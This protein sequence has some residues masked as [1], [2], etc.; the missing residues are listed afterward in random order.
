MLCAQ[1]IRHLRA[2]KDCTVAFFVCDFR[3]GGLNSCSHIL[4]TIAGH[5][6]K[7]HPTLV[8]FIYGQY[9][10]QGLSPSKANLKRLL[11]DLLSGVACTRLVVD[12][13]DECNDEEQKEIL[14]V[15]LQFVDIKS[16][17]TECKAVAFS[18]DVAVINKS[19]KKVLMISLKDEIAAA[20]NSIK[21][22]VQ[23]ELHQIRN[24]F[25]EPCVG[26]EI[27]TRIEHRL[28]S[29]ADGQ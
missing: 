16:D 25:D 17:S 10:T 6:I 4:R 13:L 24:E 21:A 28:V 7:Q 12:G 11:L 2:I 3:S 26:D 29:K 1:F 19:L 8:E 18:R 14:S 9:I 5:L 27:F 15:L 20:E 23:H 22:Y